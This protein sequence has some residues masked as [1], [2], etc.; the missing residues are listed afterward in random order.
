MLEKEANAIR[1][2]MNE[3]RGSYL[4]ELARTVHGT[5]PPP[6]IS[7]PEAEKKE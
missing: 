2:E 6:A 1:Q 7:A 4:K 3:L 5:E